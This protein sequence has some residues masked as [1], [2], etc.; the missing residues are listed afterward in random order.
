MDIDGLG[1]KLVD[2]FVR[3]GYIS[4]VADLY[5]LEYEQLIKLERF[6]HKSAKNL[7][8][9]IAAT[10]ERPLHRLI[11]ALGIRLV[12][13]HVAE[14]LA[15]EFGSLAALGEATLEQLEAV[16]E[17]GPKVAQSV[18][19]YFSDLA[20]QTLLEE[21]SSRGVNPPVVEAP[22]M[23]SLAGPDLSGTVWV[24]TGSL[25][26]YTRSEAA[27]MV[28]ALGAK[29][30]GSVS[31]KTDYLVA[32]PGAGSKLTKAQNLGISV[33]N[34]DEFIAMVCAEGEMD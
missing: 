9:S 25:V 11:F 4:T 29:A 23:E 33:M 8:D 6:A 7:V 19:D 26:K 12:G 20:V 21:L 16:N 10:R 14:V 13:A 27:A 2:Q 15:N 28:K 24:F 17:V 3:A 18:R 22:S 31:A 5:T 1:D 30:T 32:G 34:E